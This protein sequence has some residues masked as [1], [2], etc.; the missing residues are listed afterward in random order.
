MIIEINNGIRSI[1]NNMPYNKT[2]KNNA[3]KIYAALYLMSKRQN[4]F[5]YFPVPSE[6]LKAINMRY[7]KII[8]YFEEKG[9]IKA[10]QRAF[11]DENDLFNVKY[12]K[13]YD[14]N[15]G[16]TMKYKFLISTDGDSLDVDMTTNRYF[17]WYEL[18]Q[19]SLLEFGFEDIKIT[20]DNYGRR[21]HHS[22]I[23]NYKE[24][25]KGYW[26]IDSIASQPRLLYLDLKRKG[27]VDNEYNKIF[28]NDLDFYNEV[29][30]KLNIVN[31]DDTKELF[32]FWVNGRGYVPNFKIH[33]LF[34]IV[35]KYIKSMKRGD[36]KDMG[37]YLQRL[38][39]KIWIDDLLNNIPCE[40][41]IPVHDSL[42]VKEEDVDRVFDYCKIKYPE[43]K[44]SKKLIK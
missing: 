16:I 13:F 39:S 20:R 2:V 36:Y 44:F 30:Y 22:G 24:D 27:L 21:V 19:N 11:Q 8:D 29:G 32:M 25:F 34:P 12:K 10:Y 7:Y 6:Y 42:I 43:L 35:S 41:A 28:D 17:R 5:G 14:V 1:I 4:R 31:R 9:M 3:I 38:E 26:V 33:I 15:K 23:R 18:I 40:W 37:S